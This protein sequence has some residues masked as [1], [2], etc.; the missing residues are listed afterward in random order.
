M[1]K[2]KLERIDKLTCN[3]PP[4]NIEM[5]EI[6]IGTILSNKDAIYRVANI[7]KSYMFFD[8]VFGELF[9]S[10]MKVMNS[11]RQV[12]FLLLH[13]QILKDKRK[14][15]MNLYPERTDFM[16]FCGEL[17]GLQAHTLETFD[18]YCL[19]IAEK[20]LRRQQID[21]AMKSMIDAYDDTKEPFENVQAQINELEKA[22]Q[23]KNAPTDLKN[24]LKGIMR[25]I[26]DADNVNVS[27]YFNLYDKDFASII[28]LQPNR[29][30]LFPSDKGA[31]KTSFLS[32]IAEGILELNPNTAI[33][34]FC[35]EDPVADMLKKFLS[36]RV[37]LTV[38][39]IDKVDY[40]L[41]DTDIANLDKASKRIEK[42]DIEFE[43]QI[44]DIYEIKRKA[45]RFKEAR[46]TKDIIVI[47]DNFG[48]ID[49]KKMTGNN[50]DNEKAIV[51]EII[52][53]KAEHNSCIMIP[54][55][56]TKA[57][58]SKDNFKDG[59]RIRD[60]DVRGAGEILN[61]FP[62]A[63]SIV[64]PSM[65]PDIVNSYRAVT[66]FTKYAENPTQTDF[67]NDMWKLNPTG[68]LND[69][70]VTL[71]VLL[72]SETETDEQGNIMNYSYLVNKYKA[73]ID[74][75]N[76]VNL[77]RQ[78]KYHSKP[79]LLKKFLTQKMYTVCNDVC[80]PYD[81]FYYGD[82][83]VK[84]SILKMFIVDGM[85]DRYSANKGCIYRFEC[86]LE[87]SNFI[88]LKNE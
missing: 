83:K 15:I 88:G 17:T 33:L 37:R 61:Y 16:K 6:I 8:D 70:W 23:F 85:R 48:L 86:E 28:Q 39:E 66:P 34:W 78:P 22:I 25:N 47:I 84:P 76:K 2:S 44:C 1:A 46:L 82:L 68:D 60:N 79:I 80:L 45:K 5:E 67:E 54:H 9:S 58:V 55:H 43:D 53:M 69:T 26:N 24:H 59:Y 20:W 71:N 4:S 29:V 62:Q 35:F 51:N 42:Y 31:G 12:T 57:A 73:Y 36:R 50:L 32:W 21:I 49:M 77:D 56:I 7:I 10:Y 81:N 14:N 11:S 3:A 27:K 64:R 65:Y 41:T 13:E 87:Y 38:K 19:I 52:A 18:S 63:Y 30:V 40:V 75:I 74:G 72:L